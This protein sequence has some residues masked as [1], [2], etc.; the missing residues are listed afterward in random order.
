MRYQLQ[1]GKITVFKSYWYLLLCPV[2][3][4]KEQLSQATQSSKGHYLDARIQFLT[5]QVCGAPRSVCA[6]ATYF[7]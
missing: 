2:E 3:S 4:L 6:M 1:I 5:H 7:V